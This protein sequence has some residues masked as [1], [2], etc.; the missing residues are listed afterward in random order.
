M[1][2]K[3][4]LILLSALSKAPTYSNDFNGVA[5]RIVGQLNSVYQLIG[6]GAYLGGTGFLIA[7]F[8]KFK[9]HKDNPAQNPIGNPLMYLLLSVLLMFLGNIVQPIGETLFGNDAIGGRIES[10]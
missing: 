1:M 10:P 9:Q 7:T 3:I 6:A 2:F 5:D 4:G 8:F